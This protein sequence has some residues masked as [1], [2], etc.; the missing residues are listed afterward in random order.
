MRFGFRIMCSLVFVEGS[1]KNAKE[2]TTGQ[3]SHSRFMFV[4]YRH[5][6]DVFNN[7]GRRFASPSSPDVAS[8]SL[9]L[10]H[11][12]FELHESSP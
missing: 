1:G 3:R 6:I 10:S 5:T 12:F 8:A 11:S 4:T 7:M 2:W 9:L